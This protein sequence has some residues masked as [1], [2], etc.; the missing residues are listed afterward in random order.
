MS[1]GGVLLASSAILAL[2]LAHGK[3]PERVIVDAC[4]FVRAARLM[5]AEMAR[6]AWARRSRWPECKERAKR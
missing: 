6:G 4:V 1:Y 5:A 2:G 3:A